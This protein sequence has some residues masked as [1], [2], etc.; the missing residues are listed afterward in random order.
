VRAVALLTSASDE[1]S[2]GGE[3]RTLNLAGAQDEG[4][5]QHPLEQCQRDA[6]V[7][8]PSMTAHEANVPTNRVPIAPDA[9]HISRAS[10]I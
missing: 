3:T 8:L 7:A 4:S 9:P 1:K 6:D 5:Y 10:L 2:S